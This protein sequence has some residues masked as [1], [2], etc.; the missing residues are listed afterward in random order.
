MQT[1]GRDTGTRSQSE[2]RKRHKY[3]IKIGGEQKETQVQEEQT[4]SQLQTSERDTSTRSQL[5]T[6]ERET[7]TRGKTCASCTNGKEGANAMEQ[8][9]QVVRKVVRVRDDGVP[10]GR[11]GETQGYVRHFV[12]GAKQPA[13]CQSKKPEQSETTRK[14]RR[15][16]TM[17]TQ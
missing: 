16:T 3:T 2:A 14:A 17:D 9:K 13:Q 10:Q 5:E 1:S 11:L 4:R 12:S 7:S 6:S 8:L 15:T